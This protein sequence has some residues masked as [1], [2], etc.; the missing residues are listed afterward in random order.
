[1]MDKN[2][3]VSGRKY[4]L[5]CMASSALASMAISASLLYLGVLA[6]ASA[7]ESIRPAYTADFV[8]QMLDYVSRDYALAVSN[9]KIID[10]DEYVEQLVVSG[11][12]LEVGDQVKAIRSQPAIRIDIARL[13]ELIKEKAQPEAIKKQALKARDAIYVAA[14]T[15]TAPRNWPSL[16][17]GKQIF[18]A[19]C[20][21]CHGAM[22]NGRGVA[23]QTLASKPMNFLDSAR[24]ASMSPMSVFTSVKL[25]VQNTAMPS[26]S[27]LT[28]DELWAV[29]FYALSLR[30]RM[31]LPVAAK[32]DQTA[33]DLWL[34][35]AA[36]L[37]D[38]ELMQTLPGSS[39]ERLKSLALLRSHSEDRK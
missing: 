9:G 32:L 6:N 10:E 17:L 16:T 34:K 37:P 39:S 23:A 36:T 15:A 28:E 26:F 31:E 19:N 8:A 33:A 25:G 13:I 1:M 22:G 14:G 4:P 24:M 38:E 11:S 12:A 20:T 29:S 27:S 18:T 7:Q 3:A 2:L 30:P 21:S 5:Q 35:A